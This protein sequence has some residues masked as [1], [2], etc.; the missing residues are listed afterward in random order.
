METLGVLPMHLRR[1]KFDSVPLEWSNTMNEHEN[2][3]RNTYKRNIRILFLNMY[4]SIN[5]VR[6]GVHM[7]SLN[8]GERPPKRL[9]S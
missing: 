2:Y 7:S 3:T 5:H 6:E 4:R 8:I 1:Y 9:G